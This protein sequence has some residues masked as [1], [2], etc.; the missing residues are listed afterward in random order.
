MASV[1]IAVGPQRLLIR[2][3][4][5]WLMMDINVLISNE[6]EDLPRRYT[7]VYKTQGI[8]GVA[9]FIESLNDLITI[10]SLSNKAGTLQLATKDRIK[11]SLVECLNRESFVALDKGILLRF[12]HAVD[13]PLLEIESCWDTAIDKNIISS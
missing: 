6:I 11:H 3:A 9:E 12:V 8:N 1:K 4:L 5:D 10:A 7:Q 13:I 2:Y